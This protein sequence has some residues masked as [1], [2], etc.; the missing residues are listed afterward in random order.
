MAK[1]SGWN[2]SL[3][4]GTSNDFSADPES[5][6]KLINHVVMVLERREITCVEL[7]RALERQQLELEASKEQVGLASQRL[8][9]M[10]ERLNESEGRLIEANSR[11]SSMAAQIS[12]L[13]T[14]LKREKEQATWSSGELERV[15]DT[16]AAFRKDQS[17]QIAETRAQA[18]MANSQ[19]QETQQRLQR[20]AQTLKEREKQ[21]SELQEQITYLKS[22]V[23]VNEANFT[24][25]M[26][27]SGR[28]VELYK[29]ASEEASER[30]SLLQS[31][32][33]EMRELL[34]AAEAQESGHSADLEAELEDREGVIKVK[35][36]QLE[37]MRV[38]LDGLLKS[39]V[40]GANEIDGNISVYEGKLARAEEE[41]SQMRI[42]MQELVHELNSRGPLLESLQLE[43]S[44]LQG[45]VAALTDQLIQVASL[46]DA[47]VEDRNELER[48][49]TALK[50]EKDSIQQEC[51][52]LSQQVQR[53]LVE[54][55][56]ASTGSSASKRQ[57]RGTG[58]LLRAS[59]II[60][61]NLVDLTSVAQLQQRNQELLRSLRGIT[62]KYEALEREKE[63]P[64]LKGQL[65][66]ALKELDEMNEARRR[67]SQMVE[68]ILKTKNSTAA[69]NESKS[70]VITET[71][72]IEL[73]QLRKQLESKQEI[74]KKMLSE[75]EALKKELTE[76][77]V[78]KARLTAQ[79]ELN[80]ERFKMLN[81]TLQHDRLEAASVR[82]RISVQ[83]ESFN[84]AQTSSFKLMA[85]LSGAQER[86]TRLHGQIEKLQGEINGLLMETS[87][88]QQEALSVSG[89]R[90]RLTGL[91][92]SMQGVLSE[93]EASE[94][95]L[96]RH[97]TAQVEFMERELEASRARIS[98][99]TS[100]H[101]AALNTLERDRSELFRRL[102][103]LSEELSQRKENNLR[104]EGALAQA[105]E[106]ILDLERV[107]QQAA[108]ESTHD[109]NNV[110][111]FELRI[112]AL[113]NDLKGQQAA[114]QEATEKILVLEG[115]LVEMNDL[116]MQ[117]TVEKENSVALESSLKEFKAESEHLKGD[118]ERLEEELSG[119]KD[120]LAASHENVLKL[121]KE[122]ED[123]R[124][125]VT[126]KTNENA[127]LEE[128]K[129]Q[130]YAQLHESKAQCLNLTGLMTA[131]ESEQKHLKAVIEDIELRLK[132][133]QQQNDAL[134]NEAQKQENVDS[135]ELGTGESGVIRFLRDE[136][137]KLQVEKDRLIGEVRHFQVQA[138]ESQRIL[139]SERLAVSAQAADYA[140]LLAEV[141][142]LN[143]VRESGALQQHESTQ[144]KMKMS[145]LESQLREKTG[146]LA[147]LKESLEAAQS[148]IDQ[149]K[150][151]FAT[152]QSDRDS[153]K[154]RFETAISTA[155]A[156]TSPLETELKQV[157]MQSEMFRQ[158]AIALTK[159]LSEIRA[160]AQ[161]EIGVLKE[162]VKNLQLQLEN[163]V[164]DVEM[165]HTEAADSDLV[166]EPVV[167]EAVKVPAVEVLVPVVNLNVPA[168]AVSLAEQQIK[169]ETEEQEEEDEESEV[170][171]SDR[172]HEETV[173]SE[174]VPIVPVDS[175]EPI[176][177]APAEAA[178]SSNITIPSD[179]SLNVITPIEVPRK[180][181]VSLAG[182][183]GSSA[184]SSMATKPTTVTPSIP[185]T[186]PS[187]ITTASG[188][189]FVPVT[190]PD[191]PSATTS[192]SSAP[193][194]PAKGGKSVKK[195]KKKKNNSSE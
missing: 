17:V 161:K 100:S 149:L 71:F 39:A 122:I 109:E 117:L 72:T 178:V 11:Q 45:D 6:Y 184:S 124:T 176:I 190:F 97:F 152:I 52:D 145:M 120:Q 169:S 165:G 53:L 157:K 111:T 5:I 3:S 61:E 141:E 48:S 32:I 59:E 41:C 13:Q 10:R 88:L 110:K 131:G 144:M 158:R 160:E 129:R 2:E 172:E 130:N 146:A 173:E 84:Q 86:E 66:A 47:S 181:I 8:K 156:T 192:V 155:S 114:N 174:I 150:E 180:K 116:K 58:D 128:E 18:E 64:L 101:S 31:E 67:Q 132:G 23:S 27:S 185:T 16:F 1:I 133:L 60:T 87:R 91:L 108:T 22:Q 68:T 50:T 94:A 191:P 107:L 57:R 99:I 175:V 154:L 43:N 12:T 46:R 125:E 44:R 134:L 74:V 36:E 26:N 93:H 153:W 166:V 170:E 123:L 159:N 40:N 183:V 77:K 98:E 139:N 137:D 33:E 177:Q 37:K 115:Q 15:L 95:T 168:L 49:L 162:E 121:L 171:Q 14:G 90:D 118:K 7:N 63:S 80:E 92:S 73:E 89:E 127:L 9:E 51:D 103:A 56:T 70:S 138:E 79:I 21:V 126:S 65:E 188:K 195:I 193:G 42:H 54:I 83:V 29:N 106:K 76:E 167:V 35:E 25:E 112:R 4:R 55:E 187:M 194:S 30:V 104:L 164:G 69:Q 179:V 81:E 75:L 135:D 82:E 148:E 147:P 38:A 142:R 105:Q 78:T 102:E 186:G 34:A 140:R 20:T 119:L 182:I 163:V 28:L 19:A 136:K 113:T 96:K 143:S 24:R 85:D 189:K 62:A 151:S